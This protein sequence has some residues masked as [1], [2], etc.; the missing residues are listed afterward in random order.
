MESVRRGGAAVAGEWSWTLEP[1]REKSMLGNGLA[2][3]GGMRAGIE[4][5]RQEG[6]KK[7]NWIWRSCWDWCVGKRDR[8]AG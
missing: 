1:L 8:S 3:E 6:G 2:P 7:V 4:F 5:T